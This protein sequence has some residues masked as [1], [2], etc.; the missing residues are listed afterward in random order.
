MW[1]GKRS[2]RLSDRATV[3]QL[4]YIAGVYRAHFDA[5]APA[6]E[7][8]VDQARWPIAW[9]DPTPR[10]ADAQIVEAVT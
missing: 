6:R 1:V 9:D 8:F 4:D 3:D 7:E 5:H 2:L 10:K